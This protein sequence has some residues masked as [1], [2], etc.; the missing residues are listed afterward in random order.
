M[1]KLILAF[2]CCLALTAF[3]C[4]AD[5]SVNKMTADYTVE[6]NGVCTV[7]QTLELTALTAQKEL[8]IPVGT[9]VTDVAVEGAE[10]TADTHDG[11]TYATLRAEDGFSGDFTVTVTGRTVQKARETET[12]QALDLEMVCGQWETKIDRFSF[13]L[14]LPEGV[15]AGTEFRSGCHG[16]DVEDGLT[17]HT[18]GRVISGMLR[19]GLLDRDSLTVTLQVP[20]GTFSGARSTVT[21]TGV[22]QWV[23]T[24]LI[25]LLTALAAYYWFR[26]LRCGRLRVQAR[27][28]AP[29]GVTPAELPYLLCGGRP[30][31]ALLLCHWAGLGYLTME[32]QPGGRWLLR[33]NMAMGSERRE[34]EQKLFGLLFAASDV[35]EVGS[36]RHK[37][38][39]ELTGTAL[40][41]YW[42]RR[43][44]DRGSGNPMLLR[45]IASL[46]SG[47]ALTCTMDAL[48]P[49]AGLK[50]LL[51]IVAF[52]AGAFCG[53]VIWYGCARWMVHDWKWVGGG[54]A[55]VLLL[56]LLGRFG[57]GLLTMLLALA[58]DVAVGFVTTHGGRLTASGC[59]TVEQSMGFRR[60]L[61]RAE[62]T[63][64]SSMVRKDPQYFYQMLPAAKA[65]GV[66]RSFVRRTG[67]QAMEPCHWAVFADETPIR[68]DTFLQK[69]NR[70][71]SRLGEG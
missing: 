26:F 23:L 52:A 27:T 6:D 21:V 11:V 69:F 63:H 60:F 4:A 64:I 50:W 49:A 61:G 5:V 10:F 55:A 18:E 46:V 20:A 2:F 45:L 70:L 28:L 41:R 43:L 47:L 62:E 33:R 59:D 31:G 37:K 13:T 65:V 57:G 38:F 8:T 9:G 36:A 34:E 29:E 12:G 53:G 51:L 54:I 39:M 58:L 22:L 44:F 32:E 19:G 67:D 16:A 71:L 35:C 66:E 3:A 56:Y 14:M 48:L 30:D 7:K 24:V 40:R 1:R 68:A 17:L 25:L 15:T 42:N